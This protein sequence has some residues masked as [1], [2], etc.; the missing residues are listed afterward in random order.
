M[1]VILEMISRGFE[2]LL[3]RASGPLHLRLVIMP[4]VVTI[5]AVRAGLR[6][7]RE[8]RPSFLWGILTNPA[9]RRRRLFAG[10]QDI[11]RI[12]IVAIVLDTAYQIMVLRAFYVVQALIVAVACAIVPYVLFRGST[13]LLVRSLS[14]MKARAANVSAGNTTERKEGP[15]AI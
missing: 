4:T 5:P 1:D 6:D 2:Q 9:D 8:G 13:T 14:G 11:T 12:F 3:G 15:P 10:W 7:A